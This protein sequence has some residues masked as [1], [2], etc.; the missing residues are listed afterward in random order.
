MFEL[1]VIGYSSQEVLKRGDTH[2]VKR[3]V[4]SIKAD[5]QLLSSL[6]FTLF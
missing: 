1:G 4:C 6:E 3:F 2:R 5:V